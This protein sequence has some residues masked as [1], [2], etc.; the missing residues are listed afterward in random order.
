[1]ANFEDFSPIFY[2]TADFF[3]TGGGPLPC[4]ILTSEFRETLGKA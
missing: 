3:A 1:M 2:P 4:K